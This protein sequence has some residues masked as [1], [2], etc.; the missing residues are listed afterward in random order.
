MTP[1][2]EKVSI[3]LPPDLAARAR[4]ASKGNLSDYLARALEEKLLADAMAEY[5]RLRA[6]E[7][8]DDVHEAVEEDSA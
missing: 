6:A 8:I 3:T 7:A 5:A 1:P 2:R 4:A